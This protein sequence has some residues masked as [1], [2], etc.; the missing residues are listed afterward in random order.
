MSVENEESVEEI[1]AKGLPLIFESAQE[2]LDCRVTLG[3]E[4]KGPTKYP[5][6]SPEDQRKRLEIIPKGQH[7]GAIRIWKRLAER[8]I[9]RHEF[10]QPGNHFMSTAFLPL[11]EEF[12][13]LRERA[14]EEVHSPKIS[15][16]IRKQLV[17]FLCSWQSF[18]DGLSETFGNTTAVMKAQSAIAQ[19][20]DLYDRWFTLQCEKEELKRR[21]SRLKDAL[22]DLSFEIAN[23]PKEDPSVPAKETLRAKGVCEFSGYEVHWSLFIGPGEFV[24]VG[25]RKYS[26]TGNAQWEIIGRFLRSIKAG[27][28]HEPGR[29]PVV[30]TSNDYNKCKGGCRALVND[31]I[32][33]QPAAQKERNRRFE[34]R[35][36]FK[37]ELLGGKPFR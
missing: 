29:Y 31:F 37:V 15:D 26:F 23:L 10:V 7:E 21:I 35:A 2:A 25:S 32:E 6:P 18:S 34:D 27:D 36:R 33:R 1:V 8:G 12:F 13:A 17:G 11:S 4:N 22:D 3:L 5:M 28:G 20:I 19:V 24:K 14:G 16:E 30:F 9:E